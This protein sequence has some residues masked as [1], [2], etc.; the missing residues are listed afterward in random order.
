MSQPAVD[1]GFDLGLLV[2]LLVVVIAAYLLARAVRAVVS[3]AAERLPRRRL[4]V[5]ILVPIVSFL[6][7]GVAGYVILVPVLGVSSTQLLAISGLLAA[8]LG[9]GLRDLFAGVI[10]G[11]VIITEQPYRVGDKV[12]IGDHYGE[13]VSIGL[14]STTLRTPDDTAV[15]VP[16]GTLFTANVANAND[17][18][19]EMMV[20]VEVDIAPE[21]DLGR[22]RTIL[23][24]AIV[25]SRYVFVDDDHPVAVLVDD[26]T[27]YRTLRGKAYVADLRDEFAFAS[28]VTERALD[29]FEAAGVETP[30]YPPHERGRGG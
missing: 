6:I 24:E 23:E 30:E 3:A 18:S 28:D 17:G 25:T 1:L 29:G 2:D 16:N 21:A 19:P 20:V 11:L 27:Y 15:T 22:A 4:S 7:Y 10:G 13:V 8:A 12:T 5:K 9:F 14:R 26:E